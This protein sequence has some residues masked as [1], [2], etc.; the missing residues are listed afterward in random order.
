MPL[1]PNRVQLYYSG[2]IYGWI[3]YSQYYALI[4]RA[5]GPY[6]EIFV[7]TFMA[8]RPNAVRSMR[9]ERQNKYFRVWTELS[10]NMSLRI[11]YF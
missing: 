6:A 11:K 9:H 4:N 10:V 1:S 3:K 5:R 2:K 7:L 8:Y